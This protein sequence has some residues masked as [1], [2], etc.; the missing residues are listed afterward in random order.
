[1]TWP[2][3]RFDYGDHVLIVPLEHVRARVIDLHMF[4][5]LRAVEYDV[6]YFHEGVERKVRV[7][8]DELVAV[9]VD[10]LPDSD[11]PY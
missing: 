3:P 8:E 7:F 1:M 9:P 4:G 6:R 10:P 11:I 5:Q 2:L